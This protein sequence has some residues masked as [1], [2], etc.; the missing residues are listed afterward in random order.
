MANRQTLE[1]NTITVSSL[2]V[3]PLKRG[4]EMA[5]WEWVLCWTWCVFMNSCLPLM[6]QSRLWL[7]W[8]WQTS[9]RRGRQ[10]HTSPI[11]SCT[12]RLHNRS[13][14]LPWRA[15]HGLGPC[16][17]MKLWRLYEYLYSMA[18]PREAR[19]DKTSSDRA[20]RLTMTCLRRRLFKSVFIRFTNQHP[21]CNF[22]ITKDSLTQ[23]MSYDK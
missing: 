6:Y 15:L 22:S 2:F 7:T 10:D 21:W 14:F 4:H 8:I 17:V 19:S 16:Y 13:T 11:L 23:S 9:S 1:K 18:E 5:Q 20:L 3:K 12:H